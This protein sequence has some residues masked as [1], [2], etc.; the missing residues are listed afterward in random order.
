MDIERLQRSQ[1]L[2][3]AAVTTPMTEGDEA[4]ARLRSNLGKTPAHCLPRQDDLAA[5]D[6]L[7]IA[8]HGARAIE[9]DDD[10]R[11]LLRP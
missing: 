6:A 8:R 5:P 4:H 1:Q 10:R 9:D 7:D 3:I 2:H 11:G